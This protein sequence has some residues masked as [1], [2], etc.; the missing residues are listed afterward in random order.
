MKTYKQ[1]VTEASLGKLVKQAVKIAKKVV[2]MST[3]AH[4]NAGKMSKV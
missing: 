2:K 3:T 4:G 1:F